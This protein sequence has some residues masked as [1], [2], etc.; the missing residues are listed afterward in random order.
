MIHTGTRYAYRDGTR[1][2]RISQTAPWKTAYVWEAI[3][4]LRRGGR[5]KGRL[6]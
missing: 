2:R 6:E 5:P 3:K 4:L 1:A